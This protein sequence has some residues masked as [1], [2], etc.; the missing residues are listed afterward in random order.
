MTTARAL[1]DWQVE[2]GVT[3]A[4]GDAP[5]DRY[6]L[7]EAAPVKAKAAVAAPRGHGCG[8]PGGGGRGAGGRGRVAGRTCGGSGGATTCAS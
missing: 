4:V 8:G 3:E 1:L 2:L 7:A 5:V 6:A